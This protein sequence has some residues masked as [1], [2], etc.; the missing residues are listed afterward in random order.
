MLEWL[1]P[2][3]NFLPY[4]SRAQISKKFRIFVYIQPLFCGIR[5]LCWRF[6]LSPGVNDCPWARD[7]MVKRPSL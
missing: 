4:L 2:V 3:N 6:W 7:G 5:C 1:F